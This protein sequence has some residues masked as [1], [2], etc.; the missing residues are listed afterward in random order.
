MSI[1]DYIAGIIDGEGCVTIH[2]ARHKNSATTLPYF[3]PTVIVEMRDEIIT[4]LLERE[5]RG[6]TRPFQGKDN[7]CRTYRWKLTGKENLL[8]F[9][10]ALKHRLILKQEHCSVLEE[11]FSIR[12]GRHTRAIT[13][14][15][16]DRMN[17]CVSRI[18][19]LNAKG[20]H[21]QLL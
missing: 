13:E 20:Q 17:H 5:F 21:R 6:S 2:T 16:R 7:H 10:R 9:I 11:Y 15:E 8:E 19:Q 12:E 4:D 3:T 1:L 18:R 14:E